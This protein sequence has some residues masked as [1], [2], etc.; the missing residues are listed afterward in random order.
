MD[1]AWRFGEVKYGSKF[2]VPTFKSY[3]ESW[4]VRLIVKGSVVPHQLL[5]RLTSLS[6]CSR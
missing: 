6:T 2:T 4:M 5:V 3:L 1:D